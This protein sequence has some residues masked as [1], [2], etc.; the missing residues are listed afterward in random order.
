MII[1]I[2]IYLIFV[3]PLGIK[4][5]FRNDNIP[6]IVKISNIIIT[7]IIFQY[8][9]G[10]FRHMLWDIFK[11]GI[12][13][14]YSTQEN[15]YFTKEFDLFSSIIYFLVSLYTAGLVLNLAAKARSQRLF[16]YTSPIIVIITSIDFA[17]LLVSDYGY[18]GDF[19]YSILL[20]FIFLSLFFGLINVF[21]FVNPGKK[22]FIS[23]F[24]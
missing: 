6:N 15:T 21:Y 10:D 16:L 5:Y 11:T 23:G 13:S 9:F 22:L 14:F 19:F 8:Y 18:E 4:N 7:F 3:I 12:I 17:K 1:S 2:L 24:D 20:S